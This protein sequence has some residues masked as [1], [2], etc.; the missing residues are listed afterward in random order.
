[1]KALAFF[2]TLTI[3]SGSLHG[4]SNQNKA[5]RELEELLPNRAWKVQ[6][7]Y[8]ASLESVNY[9]SSKFDSPEQQE[10]NLHHFTKG[11]SSQSNWNISLNPRTNLVLIRLE[12]WEF[13][14]CFIYNNT[15]FLMEEIARTNYKYKI[16]PITD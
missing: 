13:K 7:F 14:Q 1:M 5:C 2:I 8:R 3:V 12:G 11:E 16:E 9:D 6:R 10:N 4:Q 15:V